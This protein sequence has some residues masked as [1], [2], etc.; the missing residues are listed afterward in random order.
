MFELDDVFDDD[1][2]LEDSQPIVPEPDQGKDDDDFIFEPVKEPSKTSSI[3][4]DFLATKGI[5]DSKIQILNDKNET[6]EVDFYSLSKEE[7]LEILN[8]HDIPE[9]AENETQFLETLRSN[10]ITI[11]EFLEKYKDTI[12]NE[13]SKN[14]ETT[15]EIDNYDDQELFL[16]DLKNKFELTDEELTAELEK[17]L[18]NEDIFKKKVSRLREEYKKL[19]EDYKAERE[20]E[21][22]KQREEEYEQFANSMVDIAV[23]TPE[24]YGIE[25][26]DNEKNEVLSFLLDLDENGVSNFYKELNNPQKLYEAAWFL[27]YSKDVFD[28]LRNAYEEQINKLKDNPVV[29]RKGNTNKK[30][31]NSIYDIDFLQD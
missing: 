17:E 11:D 5:K 15:Y 4:D 8:S 10:N 26:D 13:L 6:E 19:E 1:L 29:V 18:Q 25:L 27:R 21:F 12:I 31:A 2:Q 23:K 3:L 14:T 20:A 24:L 7:Q 30:T 9:L 28:V 16:L 22:S